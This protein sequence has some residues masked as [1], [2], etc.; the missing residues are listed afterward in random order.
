MLANWCVLSILE[1]N[2]N[3]RFRDRK[4]RKVENLSR[5]LFVDTTAK[6]RSFYVLERKRTTCYE[7]YKNEKKARAS[8]TRAKLRTVCEC[9]IC[10]FM[11]LVS[12]FRSLQFRENVVSLNIKTNK[13][14]FRRTYGKA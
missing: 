9:Q 3:Q 6:L 10:K 8:A 2:S 5:P 7:M 12:C 11:L 4:S 1:L 13:Q 14:G